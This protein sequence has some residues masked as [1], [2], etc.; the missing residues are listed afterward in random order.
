MKIDIMTFRD[1]TTLSVV[2]GY[3]VL[4]EPTSWYPEDGDS[5]F[6]QNDNHLPDYTELRLLTL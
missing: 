4:E 6:L 3:N 2:H 1:A 5:R